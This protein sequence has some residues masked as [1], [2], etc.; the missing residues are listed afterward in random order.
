MKYRISISVERI[1]DIG[2]LEEIVAYSLQYYYFL[3]IF[4]NSKCLAFHYGC[5][6]RDIFVLGKC[7]NLIVVQVNYTPLNGCYPKF[8][9]ETG[10]QV[11][12]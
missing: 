1:G 5:E 12:N 9:I 10:K 8:R 11:G 3:Y 7:F 6:Y 4:G 2:L